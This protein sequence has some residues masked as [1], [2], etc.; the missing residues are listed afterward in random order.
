MPQPPQT[1]MNTLV[2]PLGA[3]WR[4]HSGHHVQHH[5]PQDELSHRAGPSLQDGKVPAAARP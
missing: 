2:R 3:S 1:H 5:G 4:A